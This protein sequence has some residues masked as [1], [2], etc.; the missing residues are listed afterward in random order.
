MRQRA[1]TD[2]MPDAAGPAPDATDAMPDATED[3]RDAVDAIVAQWRVVRPDLDSSPV[4]VVGRMH[5]VGDR[6]RER[7]IA[8]YRDFGLGEGEF[9]VLATLRRADGPLQPGELAAQTMVTTG[10]MTKRLDR[11]VAAG[12]VTREA[13]ASDGRTR[14][15]VLTREGRARIDE[16]YAAHLADERALLA[17]LDDAD[18]AAL[19]AI[20]RRWSVALDEGDVATS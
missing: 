19:A 3:A 12:L 5:R 4:E 18:R 20:L 8:R 13:G 14:A 2:A 1:S 17:P 15:V 9:D 7:L 16:A 10:G 11:L 6:L